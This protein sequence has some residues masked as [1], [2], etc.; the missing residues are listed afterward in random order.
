MYVQY[1]LSA[2]GAD[3]SAPLDPFRGRQ[4]LVDLTGW[5]LLVSCSSHVGQVSSRHKH[6]QLPWKQFGAGQVV[7]A[8]V[9]GTLRSLPSEVSS[10][11]RSGAAGHSMVELS[12]RSLEDA[13]GA[14][15]KGGEEK[16]GGG[17]GGPKAMLPYSV[18]DVKP[19]QRVVGYVQEIEG[20]S[21][22]LLLSP[23][24]RG[25]LHVLDTASDPRLLA[26]FA[27]RFTQGQAVSCVVSRVSNPS[28]ASPGHAKGSPAAQSRV[29]VDLSMRGLTVQE[30]AGAHKAPRV[31][32]GVES[33]E[34][35]AGEEGEVVEAGG[36][37]EEGEEGE[38]APGRGKGPRRA[39]DGREGKGEAGDKVRVDLSRSHA[40]HFEPGDIVGGRVWRVLPGLRGCVIQLANHQFARLAVTELSDVF[41]DHPMKGFEEGQF[42][43]CTVIRVGGRSL[44][45]PN[46]VPASGPLLP[47]H[48]E[49]M[50]VSLRGTRGGCDGLLAQEARQR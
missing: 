47:H 4:C 37:G 2:E 41:T 40:T 18:E 35:R 32:G 15:K 10:R 6:G 46:G 48:H 44:G 24:L 34:G 29:T 28:K 17:K 30:P 45:Q 8:K 1:V 9:L 25:R 21:V 3:P 19:G 39:S 36:E 27:S 7:K 22:W 12:I 49:E 43:R 13:K 31:P 50:E 38:T 26:A 23:H 16:G 11:A 5:G 20:D 42:V 14:P 33:G